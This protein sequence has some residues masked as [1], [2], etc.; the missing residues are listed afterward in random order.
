MPLTRRLA[1]PVFKAALGGCGATP[2]GMAGATSFSLL[3][4]DKTWKHKVFRGVESLWLSESTC[5]CRGGQGHMWPPPCWTRCLAT[6]GEPGHTLHVILLHH[7]QPFLLLLGCQQSD[8][9]LLP[10]TPSLQP[11]GHNPRH[12]PHHE[13]HPPDNNTMRGP[14]TMILEKMTRMMMLMMMMTMVI[15]TYPR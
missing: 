6:E 4:G 15:P 10:G 2:E 11:H 14:L 8:H 3:S 13:V 7:Q 12:Y 1:D 9:L 5:H